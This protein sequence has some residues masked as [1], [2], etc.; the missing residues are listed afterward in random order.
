MSL[1][2]IALIAIFSGVLA[3]DNVHV[4]AAHLGVNPVQKVVTLLRQLEQK[5]IKD[6]EAEQ[7]SFEEYVDW[8]KGG[9]KDLEF[10]IV[11]AKSSIEGLTATIAKAE[12]DVASL[13][14]KAEGLGAAIA[15]NEADMKAA[16]EI[17]SREKTDFEAS[18]KELTDAIDTL[19]RAINILERKMQGSAL[20]QARVDR[21]D[22]GQLIQ[23]LSAVIDAAALSIHDRQ[24][25]VG[26]VQSAD[27][28]S[29]DDDMGA[30]GAPAAEVYKGRSESIVDVLED[31]K[32][33][34]VT[35]LQEAQKQEMNAQHNFELL[36]QSLE[37]Q[38]K[39][40]TEELSEAKGTKHDAAETKATAEGALGKTQEDLAN[41][42]KVL[43][44]MKGDC[45]ERASDHDVTVKNR[46]EELKAISA[47]I[48]AITGSTYS[49]ANLVY[50]ETT[51]LQIGSGNHLRTGSDLANFEVVNLLR[52]LAREQKSTALAQ[53][54]GRISTAMRRSAGSGQDPFMKVKEMISEMVE[55]LQHEA[56]EEANHK[57]YCDKEMAGTKQ[58]IEELKYD[59][60]KHGAKIDKAKSDSAILK[61][62]LVTL[63][64]ELATIARSQSTLDE[65]RRS[66]HAAYVEAKAHLEE[67]LQGVRLGLKLLRDYYTGEA[68]AAPSGSHEAASGAGSTI[69]GMLEVIESDLGKSLASTEAEE[70]SAAVDY[71]KQS[72]DNRVTTAMKERDVKYKTKEAAALDKTVTEVSSD[73]DS[74]QTELDAVLEYSA[75]IRGMCELKPE[76]YEERVERRSAEIQG[77]RE[78]LRILE[79]EAVLLQQSH[80]RKGLRGASHMGARS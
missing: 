57:A 5:I 16:A 49:A 67:G 12:S 8:C 14:S 11:T 45:M 33:K 39:V 56:G 73:R 36:K 35:Q 17:R 9:A 74:A 25:L 24:K 21:K 48:E 71:E 3:V 15:T 1:G 6:G 61:D 75:N 68:S 65:M 47:A 29:D 27:S 4:S 64:N 10:E 30:L 52:K 54:A 76:T 32:Q 78:A 50:N 44:N 55:R 37:D 23:T 28:E 53:L 43:K 34:A 63:S 66:E 7:K 42:E 26:L 58:K 62:E 13:E 22:I 18:E 31:L 46:A 79:G 60:E 41:A 38:V 72:Q 51:F 80:R 70:D 69:I 59:I 77:L 20:L 2:R 40:D 19:E